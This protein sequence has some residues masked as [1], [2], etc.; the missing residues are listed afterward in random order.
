MSDPE[1]Q[2]TLDARG[3]FCPE[4]VMML[5]NTIADIDI[6]NVVEILATD[7]S[8]KRDFVK[9]CSFLGHEM[10]ASEETDGEFR[11]LIRKMSDD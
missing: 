3:L 8:T 10:L 2:T 7:P 6:G 11:F 4:P 9:F 5:H 1:V